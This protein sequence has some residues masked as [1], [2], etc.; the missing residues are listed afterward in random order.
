M[1]A[2]AAVRDE[3]WMAK[4]RDQGSEEQLLLLIEWDHRARCGP[5]YDTRYLGTRMRQWMDQDVQAALDDCWGHFDAADTAAAL[6]ASIALFAR[7]AHRTAAR[8]GFAPFHHDRLRAEIDD[9]L[10]LRPELAA[11][12]PG[13]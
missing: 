8:L 3:L 10:G 7:L 1:C 12:R 11:Y 13:Q 5:D 6:R 4:V 9:I 2:K